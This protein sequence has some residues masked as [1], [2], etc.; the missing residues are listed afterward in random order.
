MILPAFLAGVAVAQPV[1]P[2]PD[3]IGIYFD[4]G[5]VAG[6]YCAEAPMGSQLTAYLCLTRASQQSGF[7]AWECLLD[8]T[9][10]RM[11]ES[12]V[13]RRLNR[14]MIEL[15]AALK[16]IDVGD[17]EKVGTITFKRQIA[18]RKYG[19][20]VIWEE[21]E[22]NTPVYNNDSIRTAEESMADHSSPLRRVSGQ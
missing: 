9:V 16:A 6:S 2:E 15:G 10:A 13:V 5:A 20:Q 11:G 8:A 7:T 17:L 21:I 12:P 22:K 4:E 19:S 3:G 14:A 1:D 18:Q